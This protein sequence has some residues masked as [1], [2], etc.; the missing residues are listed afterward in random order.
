MKIAYIGIDLLASALRALLREGCEVCE[1]FTCRTDNKTEFNREVIAI[2]EE[3]SLPYSLEPI[4][5]ADMDRL[6]KAGVDAV[7]CAGYYHK[8]PTDTDIPLVNI[9]PA[10][11]PIGRGAW[12][13]PITI[14]KGLPKSGVTFH[15]M[16]KSF[17]TGDI[18]LQGEFELSENEDLE[19]FMKK[20]S[21]LIEEMIPTLISDFHSLYEN[22]TP[23]GEGEYWKMPDENE[24]TVTLDMQRERVE[25]ILRA[26]FGYECYLDTEGKRYELIRG[27]VVEEKPDSGDFFELRNGGYIVAGSVNEI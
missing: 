18:L 27:R 22:A 19:S 6:K 13:M 3:L 5:K 26:F 17:D 20:V 10:L 4:S 12:P 1:I 11:L 14:L 9:H 2:A 16:A 15:K 21:V 8:V 24:Y 25:L 7:I 23:Q